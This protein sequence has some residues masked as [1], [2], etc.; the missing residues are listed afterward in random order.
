MSE[1][2]IIEPRDPLIVRD[3]RPFGP[4]PG[5][6]AKTLPF[7]F[8]STIAGGVRTRA[9]M[10]ENGRFD[11]DKIDKVKQ[12]KVKGPLLIDCDSKDETPFLVPAPRD[13]LMFQSAG[14]EAKKSIVNLVPLVPVKQEDLQCN[15][16]EPLEY[17][18]GLELIDLQKPAKGVPAFW[19]WA[20]FAD[21]L[22]NFAP[23]PT[24]VEKTEQGISS[25]PQNSRTHV[26]INP[27]SLAAREGDLFATSALEFMNSAKLPDDD[28]PSALSNAKQMGLALEVDNANELSIDQGFASL[29]GER[30]LVQWRLSP[31][32]FPDWPE[33]LLESVEKDGACRLFL[34]TPAFFTHGWQPTRLLEKRYGVKPLLKAAAVGKPETVSGWDFENRQPKPTRR[35]VP[36][37]SVY[38]VQFELEANANLQAWLKAVWM[39]CWSDDEM[40]RDA[41]FGLTAVGRW[42]G[43]PRTVEV[44]EDVDAK[45]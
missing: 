29:G 32:S 27:E 26:A 44:K 24:L 31:L 38:F 4:N 43:Q 6:R 13:M 1:L 7:P 9:G 36:A 35:L 39:D 28:K 20:K 41:G 22:S 10:D 25:L 17:T 14:E 8:P 2:W 30:R 5:A 37:G 45:T 15:L 12:M 40:L 33:G 3:G 16:P 21:W 42:D 18:V 23:K 11:T 34:L 19:H